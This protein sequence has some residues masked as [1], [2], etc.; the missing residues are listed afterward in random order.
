MVLLFFGKLA[1]FALFFIFAVIA[2]ALIV[3][4]SEPLP[5]VAIGLGP[6]VSLSLPDVILLALPVVEAILS[7]DETL[8]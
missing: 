7:T 8:A 6:G 3:V 4:D 5:F 2:F 1:C